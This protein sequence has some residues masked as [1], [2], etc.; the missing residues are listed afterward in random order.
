M[1]NKLC[2]CD[3]NS[4]KHIIQNYELITDDVKLDCLI[5]KQEFPPVG[6]AW[7]Q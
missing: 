2:D 5:C 3:A 7:P 1:G 6:T 4:H